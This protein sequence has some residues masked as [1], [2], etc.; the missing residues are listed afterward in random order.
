M[1]SIFIKFAGI[2]TDSLGNSL[3]PKLSKKG[4]TINPI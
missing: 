2:T 3:T 1:I 4:L